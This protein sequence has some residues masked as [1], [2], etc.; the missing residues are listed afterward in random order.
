VLKDGVLIDAAL[1]AS[2]RDPGLPRI[3]WGDRQPAKP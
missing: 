1:Y 3:Q 2:T